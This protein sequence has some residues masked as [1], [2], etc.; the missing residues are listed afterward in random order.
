MIGGVIVGDDIV[1]KAREKVLGFT[2]GL[3]ENDSLRDDV[4]IFIEILLIMLLYLKTDMSDE[5]FSNMVIILSGIIGGVNV[6]KDI[7]GKLTKHKK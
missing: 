5:V 7:A 2:K 4:I 1:N 6:A 3:Q